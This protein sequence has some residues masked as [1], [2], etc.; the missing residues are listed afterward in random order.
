MRRFGVNPPPPPNTAEG[1]YFKIPIQNFVFSLN[2][3]LLYFH[4]SVGAVLNIA[5]KYEIRR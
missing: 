1:Q 5:Q 2:L 4:I 3:R